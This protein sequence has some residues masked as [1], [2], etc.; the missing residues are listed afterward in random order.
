MATLGGPATSLTLYQIAISHNCAKVRTALARKRLAYET[1]DIP[2]ADRSLVRKVS[3]HGL[4]PVLRDG[5]AVIGDSTRILLHL[6]ERYPE[7]PLLPREAA[8]RAECLVLED[9]ADRA[10]MDLTRR[11][12]YW[13]ILSRSGGLARAWGLP[14]RGVR[15][16]VTSRL[17]AIAVRRRFGLSDCRNRADE[18]EV[19]HVAALAME[20]LGGRPWLIGD[21]LSLADIALATMA[22]PLWAACGPDAPKSWR[23]VH[24]RPSDRG[25]NER[26]LRI[27]RATRIS[28][29][30]TGFR[31]F[32]S[33]GADDFLRKAL[34]GG[35]PMA[36]ELQTGV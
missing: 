19:R 11:L 32:G 26:T 25:R 35:A 16:A 28:S 31:A 5:E 9:W 14:E 10:L 1:I 7:P 23:L 2:P 17:G 27:R 15:S 20:R 29:N 3:G 33:R 34:H 6:E 4:V 30:E 13:R 21:A 24:T 22:A 18:V 12:A 36:V 8:A